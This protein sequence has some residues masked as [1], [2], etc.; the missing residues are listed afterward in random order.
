MANTRR[1]TSNRTRGRAMLAMVASVMLGIIALVMFTFAQVFPAVVTL[2]ISLLGMIVSGFSMWAA[3]HVRARQ[4]VPDG[5]PP[6]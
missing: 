5:P 6:P 3:T 2:C 1:L 4:P